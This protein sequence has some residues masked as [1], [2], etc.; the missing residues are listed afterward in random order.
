MKRRVFVIVCILILLLGSIGIYFYLNSNK[1]KDIK[2]HY[3]KNVVL[4]KDSS[5]FNENKK[6]I[7]TISKGFTVEL[8]SFKITKSNDTYFKIKDTNYYLYYKDV[9]KTDKLIVDELD[10]NYLEFN[11]NIKTKDNTIFYKDDKKILSLKNLLELKILYLDEN[12]YYVK[13]LNRI[14]GI[15][16]DETQEI[17]DIEGN[18]DKES[19]YISIVNYVKIGD[20]D[21]CTGVD[22]VKEELN[23][24]KENNF[25][26]ITTSEYINW[27][28]N[29][30]RLK[31]SAILLTTNELNDNVNALKEEFG[32]N[33]ELVDEN[34]PLKFNDNNKTT[35]KESD[36]NSL[37]RYVIS[38][39]TTLDKFRQITLG[40][41]VVYEVPKVITEQ[42]TSM[43]NNQGIAVINY[44]F[45][46]DPTLGEG[47]NE[48]IC[49]EVQKFREQLNY[50]KENNFKT[51]TM[52]EFKKWMYGEIE[53]PEKSV[54]L[55]IDDG[56]FGTGRHNGNKLIPILEEYNMHATLFLITGWWDVNNY[57]SK[58]LDIQSHTND[59][60]DYGTCGKG[61]VVCASHDE[62]LADL[63]KSLQI[64]DN[65]NSFCFPF[66]SYSDSSVETVKEAG[67]KMAF[68]GGNRKATRNNNK[69]L[70]PRYPI[71]KTT[72]LQQ[73]I[74]M[75]N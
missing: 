64:V 55:T 62:L 61:H 75:V 57:R 39:K 47:C 26:T 35:T 22:K 38:E 8:E 27:K 24:L 32:V 37:S 31:E 69:Y 1:I 17:I 72:T 40:E 56:A 34:T 11:Q 6:Q 20:C 16:K 63:Q 23:Y 52:E 19:N 43:Y 42:D 7:G 67:F 74:N 21:T 44:H 30:I 54:L 73:F 18:D 36:L 28:N 10:N 58:N 45:F 48:N 41:D 15:K 2:N 5:I 68:I 59:M 65:N 70:I 14:L 49:L 53:L 33:I 50:L 3:S 71:Y 13:Y 25:Y 51:L 46:Y 9:K 66:Y 60:H 12:Y 29:F 4:T